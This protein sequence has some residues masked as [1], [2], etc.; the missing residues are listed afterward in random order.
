MEKV[1]LKDISLDGIVLTPQEQSIFTF[2]LDVLKENNLNTT[3]RVAGGWVRDKM[4][5]KE[6][7]DIDIALD[8]MF[9]QEFA[10][11]ISKKQFEIDVKEGKVDPNAL[12]N[13][14]G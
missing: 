2:L 9:G 6:S 11:I 10:E 3:L 4:Y 13:K 12:K 1:D 7:D 5:G 14:Q 8:D